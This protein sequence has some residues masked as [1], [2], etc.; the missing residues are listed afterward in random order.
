M[1]EARLAASKGQHQVVT[2]MEKQIQLLTRSLVRDGRKHSRI[3][4]VSPMWEITTSVGILE[5]IQGFGVTPLIQKLN[6][7]TAR[8][9]YAPQAK[10]NRGRLAA[11][12]G[13]H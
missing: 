2:T 1:I 12:K 10:R 5:G 4:T 7:S 11:N 13:Q 8:F 9:N 3:I 6:T